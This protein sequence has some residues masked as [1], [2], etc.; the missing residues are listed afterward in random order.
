MHEEKDIRKLIDQLKEHRALKGYHTLQDIRDKVE[1]KNLSRL[2][3]EEDDFSDDS[4]SSVDDSQEDEEEELEIEVEVPEDDEMPIYFDEGDSALEHLFARIKELKAKKLVNDYER[5]QHLQRLDDQKRKYKE[6]LAIANDLYEKWLTLR[7]ENFQYMQHVTS[8]AINYYDKSDSKQIDIIWKQ[9][10]DAREAFFKLKRFVELKQKEQ[11]ELELSNES[12]PKE[13]LQHG[14][15]ELNKKLVESE[16]RQKECEKR[17]EQC[18][19]EVVKIRD[20]IEARKKKITAVQKKID[21]IELMTARE[22]QY[23]AKKLFK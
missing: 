16:K 15:K 3:D 19:K 7:N 18:R 12:N 6:R 20:E 8:D 2:D 23:Q 10:C 14:S 22:V 21:K 1:K 5:A 17:T 11:D 9:I 4:N 13:E